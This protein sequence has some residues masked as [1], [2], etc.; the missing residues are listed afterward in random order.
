MEGSIS[1]L[2][3]T[4]IAVVTG[5]NKGI[6]LEVCRQLAGNGVTVVLTARDETRGEAALE[7]LRG[8]GLSN[9]IFHHLEITDAPS[10]ARLADF[11]KTRFGKLDI[12][13]NNA[14]VVGLEYLHDHIDGTSTTSEKFGGM[15]TYERIELLLKWCFRETCDAGKAC[16][17]TNYHGTKQVIGA[18]LPLLLAS[19]DGRIVN[20]SSELGQL[21]LFGNEALRRELDD[22]EALSE[23]RVD[24]V[25]A[26]FVRDLEAGAAADA[27]RGW[28]AGAMSA[29][30]VSK[31]ALNAY[32]R[33]LARRHPSLRV[34][35][36]HPGF[37]RTDMT[38][39][40]GL[41]TPEEG[42]SR[43]VAVALLPAGGPTGAYFQDRQQA[44]FV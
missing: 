37:V 2:P 36:V 18:L 33:V 9:V 14:G 4:R 30:T 8:L 44:P 6:G 27:A 39:N 7:K 21:R 15:D 34:N 26:A 22:L 41:L 25:V 23:A 28:P 16:L 1:N 42:A 11:L 3:S 35:C 24:E 12:L 10:I 40:F 20:L 5:G 43:V 38:V 29:Y 17:R 19:D 13:V 31:A 32:S